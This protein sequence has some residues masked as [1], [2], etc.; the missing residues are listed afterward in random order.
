MDPNT[1]A[2]NARAEPVSSSGAVSPSLVATGSWD[3]TV[4]VWDV[5]L[6]D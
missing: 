2:L 4:R 5:D 1:I 3:K 6:G